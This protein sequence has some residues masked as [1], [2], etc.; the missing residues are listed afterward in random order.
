MALDFEEMQENLQGIYQRYESETAQFKE[1]AVC[2]IGCSFCCSFMGNIDI[3]TLEGIVLLDRLEAKPETELHAIRQGLERDRAL[4]AE[5]KKSACP[6]LDEQG[7]CRVYEVRPF[8]CRQLYSLRKCD[9]GGPMIHKP[10]VALARQL[11]REIQELDDTGY[12]GHHSYIL[13]LLQNRKF[14]DL[15][16]AG[17]FDPGSVKKFGKKHGIIINRFA[18]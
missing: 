9:Q 7:A 16:G 10:A 4:R 5:G 15:Y 12:S 18:K 2:G 13:K 1:Q 11:V 8:S 14:R 3:V 6:F 17:G